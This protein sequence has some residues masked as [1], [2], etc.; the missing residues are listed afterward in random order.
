[1]IKRG[2]RRGKQRY[3]CPSCGSWSSEQLAPRVLVVPD[4]HAP[5]IRDGALE[6]LV[7]TYHEY[8]CNE[9]VFIGDIMDN[10]YSSF[11]DSDPDGLG[12]RRELDMA[13]SQLRDFSIAFPDARVCIGNHDAIPA[14]KAFSSGVSGAWVKSMK[15]VMLDYGLPVDGWDFA[16][17]HV[18]DG[19]KYVHGIGRQAKPRMIYDGE[20]IV[21]GHWHARS[22]IEWLVNAHKKTFAMQ[23]GALIDDNAY[24]MAYAK[25][26]PK[27]HKNCGLVL[28]GTPILK[29]MDL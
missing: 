16:E 11:H 17:H 1:M 21:Q 25:H 9:V 7:Q 26:F 23:V 22:S 24:A 18:I 19:V 6:F 29:Y 10:H 13:I 4:L 28:D 15:E 14:R 8:D 27:S 5:F 3:R 20:S 2:K 12:A